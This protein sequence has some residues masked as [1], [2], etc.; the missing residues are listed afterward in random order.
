MLSLRVGAS[1]ILGIFMYMDSF[2]FKPHP[3]SS[4]HY[5]NRI[6]SRKKT[7]SL[8]LLNGNLYTSHFAK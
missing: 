7:V 3:D 2:P 6:K 5:G 4:K 8:Q 1:P